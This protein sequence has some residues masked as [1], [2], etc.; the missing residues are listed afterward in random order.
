MQIRSRERKL[1]E[2]TGYKAYWDACRDEWMLAIRGEPLP[3]HSSEKGTIKSCSLATR[4]TVNDVDHA[5]L[6]MFV[7]GHSYLRDKCRK[8]GFD[9]VLLDGEAF[10]TV[11]FEDFPKLAL[12]FRFRMPRRY[13]PETLERMSRRMKELNKRKAKADG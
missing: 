13:S 5:L 11:P 6:G 7:K 12:I 8:A 10:F 4:L 1:L 3:S 2:S 9:V